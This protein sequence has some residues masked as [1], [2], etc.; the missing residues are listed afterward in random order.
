MG[1]A[2]TKYKK[3]ILHEIDSLPPVK[4]KEIL[5]FVCFIKAREAIDPTQAFFWTRG[6]QRLEQSADRDKKESRIIGD[7]SVKG[8]LDALKS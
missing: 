7:G 2:L 6:W 5:D 1:T 8:L 3:D 4:L